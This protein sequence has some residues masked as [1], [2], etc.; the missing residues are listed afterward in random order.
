MKTADGT[1]VHSFEDL[2]KQMAALTRATKEVGGVLFREVVPPTELQ[3]K[4]LELLGVKSL[5]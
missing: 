4:A 5:L 3:D 1:A 2:I